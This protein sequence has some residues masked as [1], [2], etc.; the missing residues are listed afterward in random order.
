MRFSSEPGYFL[1]KETENGEDLLAVVEIKGGIDPAG[2]LKD[3]VLQQNRFSIH[4]TKVKS[5]RT[6]SFRSIYAGTSKRIQK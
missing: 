6:F 2:A 4:C 5:V 1:F 3:M